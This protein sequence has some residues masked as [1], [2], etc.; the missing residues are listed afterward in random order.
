M[1]ESQSATIEHLIAKCTVQQPPVC[2]LRG[3]TVQYF[4]STEEDAYLQTSVHVI[5]VDLDTL[6]SSFKAEKGSS[7][8]RS[9]RTKRKVNS[10][11]IHMGEGR[12]RLSSL[13][14]LKGAAT[15]LARR[16][17]TVHDQ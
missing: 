15:P 9:R 11:P 6:Q 8:K 10:E 1:F 5:Q 3:E 14:L 2:I 16:K 17:S 4:Y 13:A 12:R 7:I